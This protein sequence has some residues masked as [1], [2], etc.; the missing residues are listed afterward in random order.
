M[1]L[2]KEPGP[3]T[4]DQ[5]R[6]SGRR[7]RARMARGRRRRTW[8]RPRLGDRATGR[9][10]PVKVA[11]SAL[12]PSLDDPV[13]E[14]FGRAA[15]LLIVDTATLDAIAVDNAGNRDALQGSGVGAAEVVSEHGARAVITGHLGPKA[16]R[17]LHLAGIPGY[18][19]AGMTVRDAVSAFEAGSLAALSEGDAHA[20]MQ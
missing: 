18:A 14:R 19:G 2:P 11:V 16:F 17:A 9:V 12:G 20:G 7:P 6:W 13:D 3:W 4:L 10:V 5:R 8:Q 15:H 1:H